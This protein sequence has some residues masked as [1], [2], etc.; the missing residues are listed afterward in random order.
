MENI[1]QMQTKRLHMYYFWSKPIGLFIYDMFFFIVITVYVAIN[2]FKQS[3]Y[4]V[5]LPSIFL[6][7]AIAVLISAIWFNHWNY[8]FRIYITRLILINVPLMAPA[9]WYFY[10]I[11]PILK[12]VDECLL[13]GIVVISEFLI[14]LATVRPSIDIVNRLNIQT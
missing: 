11:I 6:F 4:A 8:T 9:F 14:Y 3:K 13:C 7:K 10:A 12:L 1:I 2:L 5:I